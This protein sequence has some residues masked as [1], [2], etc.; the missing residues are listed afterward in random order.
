MPPGMV[1]PTLREA[2]IIGEVVR[3]VRATVPLA[4]ILVVDDDSGDGTAEE[5]A[6]AGAQVLVRH[7]P[8]GLGHA[9]REG[10]AH[11]RARGWDP[12]VQL[13]GD[14]SHDPEHLP[15]LLEGLREADLVIGSRWVPGGDV[16]AWSRRRR[17][18]SRATSRWTRT[19]LGPGPLDWTSGFRAWR[20]P[21]LDRV[22]VEA[23][24]ASDFVWQ[25]EAACCAVRVGLRIH[26]VPIRFAPRGAGRSKLSWPVAWEAVWRIPALR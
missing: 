12:V 20:G 8:R 22:L 18:L 25:I 6:R 5:A 11:A 2:S 23:I 16:S 13:D 21:A 15:A 3:R 1:I 9:Y 26:E 17:A 10:L 19:W 7:G 4:E 24:S 14:G